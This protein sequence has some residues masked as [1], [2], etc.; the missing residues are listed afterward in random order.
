MAQDRAYLRDAV[1]D[2]A[3]FV[4]PG[5]GRW[6][7]LPTLGHQF[8][9]LVS[10]PVQQRAERVGQPVDGLPCVR[11]RDLGGDQEVGRDAYQRTHQRLCDALPGSSL[12]GER[13]HAEHQHC[14]DCD[15]DDKDP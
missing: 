2:A 11:R 9:E 6:C 10:G 8:G 3:R 12:R 15:L 1:R 14:A 4:E 7:H 13:A 5:P